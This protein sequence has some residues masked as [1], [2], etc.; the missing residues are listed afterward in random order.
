MTTHADTDEADARRADDRRRDLAA[1]RPDS[2]RSVASDD[3]GQVAL[4]QLLGESGPTACARCAEA[5]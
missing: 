3:A 1:D 5:A 2:Y 4:G